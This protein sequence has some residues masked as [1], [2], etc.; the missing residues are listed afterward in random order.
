MVFVTEDVYDIQC[1][2][3]LYNT[4]AL[5]TSRM[6]ILLYIR[7]HFI[8]CETSVFATGVSC[9]SSIDSSIEPRHSAHMLGTCYAPSS[10]KAVILEAEHLNASTS[11]KSQSSAM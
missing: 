3:S 4:V 8:R 9:S 6:N 2:T 10:S 5:N 7:C 11:P 1:A